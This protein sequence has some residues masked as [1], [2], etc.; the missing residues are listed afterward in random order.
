MSREFGDGLGSFGDSVLGQFTGEDEFD[1]SLDFAG[2]HG[3]SLVVSDE[4]GSFGGESV[5]RVRHE[6]VH[7]GHGLLGDSG[8]RVHL[9]QHLVDVDAEGFDSLF[10]SLLLDSL[11]VLG[12]RGGFLGWHFE[13]LL[14]FGAATYIG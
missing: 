14:T 12:G 13:L 4:A 7:D 6:R 2:A 9:L 10:G 11:D 5:E 8:F 3:V 1:G